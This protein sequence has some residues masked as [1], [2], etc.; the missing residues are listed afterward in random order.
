MFQFKK[1]LLCVSL[2][3]LTAG[4]QTAV[5]AVSADEAAKLKTW[6]TPLG[7]EKAGNKDGT[8]PA[9]TGGQTGPVAGPKVGDIPVN[10]FPNPESVLS[11]ARTRSA[12]PSV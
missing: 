4:A 9:W 8:I 10:L 5:A 2:L 1:T 12:S 7:G 3:A 11:S 6:L